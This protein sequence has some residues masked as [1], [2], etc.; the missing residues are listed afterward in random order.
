MSVPQIP[1]AATRNSNS[2]SPISGIGTDSTTTCPLPRYTPARICPDLRGGWC[3]SMCSMVWLKLFC[4]RCLSA[5]YI[6]KIPLGP[7]MSRKR[8]LLDIGLEKIG[9]PFRSRL[10]FATESNKRR[11]VYRVI[12]NVLENSSDSNVSLFVHG[13]RE[14]NRDVLIEAIGNNSN[15]DRGKFAFVRNR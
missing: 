1:H 4:T 3:D 8:N 10:A 13:R 5:G 12:R 11:N 15:C 7:S 6:R 9:K 2:P 14:I